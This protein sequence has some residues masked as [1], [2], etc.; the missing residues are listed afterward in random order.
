[1]SSEQNIA[2]TVATTKKETKLPDESQNNNNSQAEPWISPC[3]SGEICVQICQPIGQ[4][5]AATT[6]SKSL[7]EPQQKTDTKSYP[8]ESFIIT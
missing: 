7:S 1:L 6:E 2:N 4:Q 3:P 5:D 8:P